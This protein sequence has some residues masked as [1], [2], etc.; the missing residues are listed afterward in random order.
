MSRK[1]SFYRR[2]GTP[3][4]VH[5]SI[6]ALSALQWN[7]LNMEPNK[8]FEYS[9]KFSALKLIS[10]EDPSSSHM[11]LFICFTILGNTMPKVHTRVWVAGDHIYLYYISKF[12]ISESCISSINSNMSSPV[13]HWKL[14]V[15][16]I[17]TR[18]MS[19]V[20]YAVECCK[21]RKQ[22]LVMGTMQQFKT[23]RVRWWKCQSK[24]DL[25]WPLEPIFNMDF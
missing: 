9:T 13:L 10:S 2:A 25:L 4:T 23:T 24:K 8:V 18:L 1:S 12:P 14:T 16:L 5:V 21:A 3:H 19:V 7:H 22:I 6:L 15:K 17:Y 20:W 11:F